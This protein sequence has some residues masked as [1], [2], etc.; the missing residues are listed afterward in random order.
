MSEQLKFGE[1]IE[2]LQY[3][4]LRIIQNTSGFRFGTDSVLLAGFVN[5]S[6]SHKV[7][8]LGAGTG[9]LSILI[10]GRIGAKLTAVEIQPEQCD[11]A[12]RSFK[13]NGQD[14]TLIEGDMEEAYKLT[15]SGVFDAAVCNPPYYSKTAGKL[16]SK[17]QE[18]YTAAATHEVYCNM[19]KV[20][21]SAS[22]LIKYGGKL[23]ICCPAERLAEVFT[24]LKAHSL[25]PNRIRMAAS[26]EG[27]PPYLALIEAKKG[28]APG[29]KWE[30]QLTVCN[31]DGSYTNETNEIYHRDEA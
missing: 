10:Q 23:Y 18:K 30:R 17:G 7:I 25:E 28:A 29:L 13:M 14:I 3:K 26:V 19:D 11:M 8:D 6:A 2:D 20:A 16:S 1:K 27:K 31:T 5:A 4:G 21:K 12:R 22:M 24:A 15:G 9:I